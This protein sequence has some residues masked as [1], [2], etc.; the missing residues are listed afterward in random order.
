MA[1]E[2][3]NQEAPELQTP[4]GSELPGTEEA[5]NETDAPKPGSGDAERTGEPGQTEEETLPKGVKKKIDKLTFQRR[6]AERERDRLRA[7]LEATNKE[8]EAEKVGEIGPKPNPADFDT[9]ADFIEA[10]TDW[11]VNQSEAKRK[12]DDAKQARAAAENAQ[13]AAKEKRDKE[14]R[15]SIDDAIERYPDFKETVFREE[16]PINQRTIDISAN[17]GNTGDIMYF[18][19]KNPEKA[20][21]LVEMS[22]IEATIA[23]TQISNDLRKKINKTP[24]APPP[25]KPVNGTA[26]VVVD[27]SKLS[28]DE[29]YKRRQSQRKAA[30]SK[31]QGA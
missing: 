20:R 17:F 22:T 12:S 26:D 3:Q 18:L 4:T 11:K 19:G 14:F 16:I 10:L 23:L 25:I 30:L 28:D 24:N 1:D 9:D 7:E 15:E 6:E 29:W 21:E 8:R 5:K 27:E 13:K 2:L 31:R